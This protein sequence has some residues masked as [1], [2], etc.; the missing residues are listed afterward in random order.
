MERQDEGSRRVGQGERNREMSKAIED[1]RRQEL[2][3]VRMN[4]KERIAAFIHRWSPEERE[5]SAQF[6]ADF[7]QI[8]QGLQSEQR[9]RVAHVW[10][11]PCCVNC[12]A[13]A[14]DK[15]IPEFCKGG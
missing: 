1:F 3:W 15:D 2:E 8:I 14:W 13:S 4:S 5:R 7:Y 6:S 9:R 10:E 12:N 11:G